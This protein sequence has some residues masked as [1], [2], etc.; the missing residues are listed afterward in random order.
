MQVQHLL[1]A[2]P[3]ALT[4]LNEFALRLLRAAVALAGGAL[5]WHGFG[6]L[7]ARELW[8]FKNPLWLTLKGVPGF[9]ISLLFILLGGVLVLVAWRG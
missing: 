5:V 1:G 9:I 2:P 4:D 6:G 7:L 8:I 3:G